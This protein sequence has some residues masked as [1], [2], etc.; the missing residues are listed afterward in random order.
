MCLSYPP[1]QRSLT[2]IRVIGLDSLTLFNTLT[3]TTKTVRVTP[4]TP[5][6]LHGV[7]KL[8]KASRDRVKIEFQ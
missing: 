4:K 1:P 7:L 3:E 8:L 5:V 6:T 2:T